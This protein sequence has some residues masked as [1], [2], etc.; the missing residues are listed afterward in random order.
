MA[1]FLCV[2]ITMYDDILISEIKIIIM[3]D[4]KVKNG[5]FC[6]VFLKN[7]YLAPS[8]NTIVIIAG[9]SSSQAPVTTQGVWD[10]LYKQQH[11]F[12]F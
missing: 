8:L 5:K 3:T 7:K 6:F 1:D 4:R 10:S 9:D 11:Q 2:V 12:P